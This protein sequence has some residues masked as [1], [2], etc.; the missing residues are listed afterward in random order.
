MKYAQRRTV[1]A[2]RI[3]FL[4][5]EFQTG[6]TQPGK[7]PVAFVYPNFF[8]ILGVCHGVCLDLWGWAGNIHAHA[9]VKMKPETFI[10]RH[11]LALRNFQSAGVRDVKVLAN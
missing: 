1:A 7:A 11:L 10:I 2:R 3:S 6:P 5:G 9:K 4:R 8:K